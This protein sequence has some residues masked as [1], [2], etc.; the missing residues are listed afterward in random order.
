MQQSPNKFTS[1]KF[2]GNEESYAKC[3]SPLLFAYIQN[4]IAAYASAVVE[5]EFTGENVNAEIIQLERL[6]AQVTVLEELLSECV[7]PQ[8]PES[9]QTE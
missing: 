3:I 2:E 8:Q 6:K 9:Q 1:F 4:K 5:F 7:V